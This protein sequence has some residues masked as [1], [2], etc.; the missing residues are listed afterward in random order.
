MDKLSTNREANPAAEIQTSRHGQ[1]SLRFIAGTA[2]M[3]TSFL[4]YPAYP[5]ILVILP[6]SASA[7]AGVTAAVWILSWSTFSLGAFLAGPEGYQWFKNLWRR[8][9]GDRGRK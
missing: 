4:V 5:V 7:K 3:A 6:L 2:L 1:K 9:T 8:L